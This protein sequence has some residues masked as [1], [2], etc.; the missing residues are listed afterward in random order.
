MQYTK[1]QRA[2][3]ASLDKISQGNGEGQVFAIGPAGTGKTFVCADW[4]ADA[5]RAKQYER[6]IIIRPAIEAGEKLGFLPG[7]LEEKIAP[8]SAPVMAILRQKMNAGG[9]LTKGQQSGKIEFMSVAHARGHTFERA[10]VLIDEA[11]N[12]TKPQLKMLFTRI[13]LH[14]VLC[15]TGDPEQADI[16]NSG[17]SDALGFARR[18]GVPVHEFDES[19]IVRSDICRMWSG[20]K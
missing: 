2:I 13:G 19:E 1:T 18:Q 8:F 15:V 16:H 20:W 17:L 14:S 5:L 3:R 9:A 4:A 10:I 7:T 6:L 12:C 11:Q